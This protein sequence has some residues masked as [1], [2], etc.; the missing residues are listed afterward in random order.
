MEGRGPGPLT[1]LFEGAQYDRDPE[2]GQTDKFLLYYSNFFWDP[3][4]IFSVN[5]HSLIGTQKFTLTFHT[6]TKIL[7]KV[8][9]H[10]KMQKKHKLSVGVSAALTTEDLMNFSSYFQCFEKCC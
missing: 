3:V 5:K 1:L 9:L 7:S 10:V 4:L 2:F 6:L 8:V